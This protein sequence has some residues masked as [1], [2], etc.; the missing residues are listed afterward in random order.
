MRNAKCSLYNKDLWDKF[1]GIGPEMLVTRAGSRMFPT[2]SVTFT[3]LKAEAGVYYHVVLDMMACDDQRYTYT[4]LWSWLGQGDGSA[5]PAPPH[6]LYTHPS[7][8]FT[9]EQLQM[10]VIGFGKVK[11]TNNQSDQSGQLILNSMHKYQPRVWLVK[12]RYG[13][14]RPV[15][16][17]DV[18]V[19]RSFVFPQY[20]CFTVTR[21]RNPTI[22]KFKKIYLQH[23]EIGTCTQDI[24]NLSVNINQNHPLAKYKPNSGRSGCDLAFHGWAWQGADYKMSMMKLPSIPCQPIE[25]KYSQHLCTQSSSPDP[26]LSYREF[27]DFISPT[28]LPP[29]LPI[30]PVPLSYQHA[31]DFNGN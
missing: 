21:Y 2:L 20:Q 16:N 24:T 15:A 1:L 17:L 3:N 5:D 11:L 27:K 23:G 30:R 7:G 12:R 4:W 9:A 19:C 22:I 10:R 25:W 26:S 29:L 8:P 14:N 6:R 13:D 31:T 18:E 28:N